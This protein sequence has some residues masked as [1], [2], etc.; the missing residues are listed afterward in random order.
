MNNTEAKKPFPWRC[1]NCKQKTVSEA[2][3]D[4]TAEMEHDGHA[5]TISAERL[6]T[7]K[8]T[9]CGQVM[10]DAEALAV[11]DAALRTKARLLTPQQV[12]QY[13]EAAALSE[14]ELAQALGVASATVARWES[15]VQIQPR[16]LDNLLRLFFGIQQVRQILITERI[17]TLPMPTAGSAA[18]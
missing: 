13:R 18:P 5:Y 10:L 17:S 1:T 2:T 6:K 14:E 7:P 15:G 11:L 4:Y 8:C 12:R 16:A 9:H 3:V